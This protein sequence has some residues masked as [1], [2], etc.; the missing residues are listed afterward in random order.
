MN[1][2]GDKLRSL[3]IGFIGAGR[4]GSALAWNLGDR[5]LTVPAVASLIDTDAER[6]AARIPACLC[7]EKIYALSLVKRTG[8]PGLA[9]RRASLRASSLAKALFPK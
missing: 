6:L 1:E 5:G 2:I 7:L 4:L 8:F 9:C 3:R